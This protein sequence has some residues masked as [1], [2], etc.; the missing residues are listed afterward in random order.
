MG[1]PA[2]IEE[3]VEGRAGQPGNRAG[4]QQKNRSLGPPAQPPQGELDVA[5]GAADGSCDAGQGEAGNVVG[6]AQH[7]ERHG[8][9]PRIMIAMIRP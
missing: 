1:A 4:N 3:L 9:R 2:G 5:A 6:V 8:R 7:E